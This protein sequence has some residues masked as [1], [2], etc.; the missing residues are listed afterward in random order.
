[1][2]GTLKWKK[3]YLAI[4]RGRARNTPPVIDAN[5]NIYVVVKKALLAFDKNGNQLFSMT[6]PRQF[7]SAPILGN[8]RL[9]VGSVDGYVSA[10]G[11]CP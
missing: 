11:D 8:G 1:L 9:Y 3:D 2:N 5:G 7:Q 4:G 10:I 6:T